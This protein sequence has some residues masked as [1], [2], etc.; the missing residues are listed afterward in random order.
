MLYA[1]DTM[2]PVNIRGSLKTDSV[3]QT[4]S[5]LPVT[6]NPV[7]FQTS[8]D[9]TWSGAVATFDGSVPPIYSGNGQPGLWILAELPPTITV[10]I[11]NQP[12]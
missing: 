8:L 2:S 4:I 7:S 11:G 5:L 1:F 6:L 10:K 9:I 3:A 12:F